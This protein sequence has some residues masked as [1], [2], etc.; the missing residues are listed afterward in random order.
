LVETTNENTLFSAWT[1]GALFG[2]TDEALPES[3]RH[4]LDKLW[5]QWLIKKYQT[6]NKLENAWLIGSRSDGPNLVT[7]S[8]FEEKL[9]GWV[10]EAHSPLKASVQRETL[11]PAA[12]M[13]ALRI[14]AVQSGTESYQ[15]QIKQLGIHLV[16]DSKYRL[17]FKAKTDYDTELSIG[18]GK[19]TSPWN[20]FGLSKRIALSSNW[21]EY[22]I[23]FTANATTDGDTRL[24]FGMG[25]MKGTVWLDEFKLC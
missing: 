25:K 24:S 9:D 13:G 14:A 6:R 8:G 23:F 17:R 21:Q 2:E 3:Y 22:Q 16:K 10:T 5:N 1:N 15:L 7:N 12:G 4:Q 11:A 20:N 18:F 19:N